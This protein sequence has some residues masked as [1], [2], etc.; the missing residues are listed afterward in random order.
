MN[1]EQGQNILDQLNQG[2]K[3]LSCNSGNGERIAVVETTGLEE[4]VLSFKR[5]KGGMNTMLYLDEKNGLELIFRLLRACPK[6]WDILDQIKNHPDLN[7]D[8]LGS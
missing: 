4:L 3:Y 7:K 1:K 2:L 6:N 8:C 5:K